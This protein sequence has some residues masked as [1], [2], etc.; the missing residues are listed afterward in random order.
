VLRWRRGRGEWIG[1]GIETVRSPIGSKGAKSIFGEISRGSALKE[2][3]TLPPAPVSNP[4]TSGPRRRALANARAEQPV[5]VT[6]S[7][8]GRLALAVTDAQ[9]SFACATVLVCIQR[10]LR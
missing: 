6:S 8:V 7:V 4:L 10:A 5:K 2:G 3:P 9:R 1:A